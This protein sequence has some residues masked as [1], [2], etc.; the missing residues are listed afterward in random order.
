MS[1]LQPG[2]AEGEE[3]VVIDAFD[4]LAVNLEVAILNSV[5]HKWLNFFSDYPND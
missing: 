3:A 2:S 5:D 1:L 4:S